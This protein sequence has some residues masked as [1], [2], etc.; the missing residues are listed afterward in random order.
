[1]RAQ[2]ERV[3]DRSLEELEH[4]KKVRVLLRGDIHGPPP[5]DRPSSSTSDEATG[6]PP[7]RIAAKQEDVSLVLE[8]L[9]QGGKS[10]QI[11]STG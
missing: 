3:R 4:A 2:V 9:R 7:N 6:F 11:R 8:P 1:M 5:P 10:L